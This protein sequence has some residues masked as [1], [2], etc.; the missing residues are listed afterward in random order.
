MKK[1]Q[2]GLV[3]VK[4]AYCRNLKAIVA[5]TMKQTKDGNI[6]HGVV[7]TNPRSGAR[8]RLRTFEG[9][10]GAWTLYKTILNA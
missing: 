9:I 2:S 10:S 6:K 5:L 7:I 8:T 1:T 4:E 3:I